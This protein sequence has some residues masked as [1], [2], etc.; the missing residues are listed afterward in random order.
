MTKCKEI[1]ELL[2]TKDL[3]K[4]KVEFKQSDKL[5]NGEGQKD[6]AKELVALANHSGGKLILGLKDNGDFEGKNIF[7]VDKDKGR[8]SNIIQT[9]ISPI[10]K[11]NIE[12]LPCP[13]GDLLIIHVEKK[14]DMPYAYIVSKESHEIKNRIY[15][16]KTPHDRRL[17]SDSQLKYLFQEEEINIFY[18][19][20]IVLNLTI[21]D[22]TFS[23]FNPNQSAGLRFLQYDLLSNLTPEMTMEIRS[24]SDK[25]IK[26]FQEIIPYAILLS[27]SKN[28]L[29]SWQFTIY[30]Y[31]KRYMKFNIPKDKITLQEIPNLP[32]DSLV[33]KFSLN[34]KET[35]KEQFFNDIYVP[36]GTKIQLG[37]EAGAFPMIIKNKNFEFKISNDIIDYGT[38]LESRHSSFYNIIERD[39][40]SNDRKYLFIRLNCVYEA[41]FTFPEVFDEHYTY[42]VEYAKN[43][44]TILME[45]WDFN[46]YLEKFPH[47]LIWSINNK[48]DKLLKTE[49]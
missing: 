3:E 24:D 6:L 1:Y 15:Y 5:R 27:F 41:N 18:P 31:G 39:G 35:L 25:I 30:P 9:R 12:F 34:I 4:I 48:L 43:I 42:Y 7:N 46:F 32:N 36:K 20:E 40:E 21:P 29:R 8:I 26:F 23:Y 2:Q 22:L 37:F 14:K 47:P 33:S 19:F 13:K 16:I 17:V 28:F 11:Y 44:K 38:H 10:L 45:E 49:K